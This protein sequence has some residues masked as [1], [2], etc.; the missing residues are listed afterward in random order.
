MTRP[1]LITIWDW[2]GDCTEELKAV[3]PGRKHGDTL[4][5]G[6]DVILEEVVA[7][8]VKNTGLD[9][10]IKTAAFL[11]G[12]PPGQRTMIA[13]SKVGHGFGVRG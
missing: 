8:I 13:V 6:Q 12:D 10:M 1:E 4:V 2:Y 11:K 7:D 3:G 5:N 9:V